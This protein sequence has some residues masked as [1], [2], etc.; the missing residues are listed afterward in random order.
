MAGAIAIMQALLQRSSEGGSYNIDV[1]LN[2][3]NNWL[4][5][6]VGIHDEQTQSSIRALHPDFTPRHDT[7][8]FEMVPQVIETIKKSNGVGTGQLWDEA[9]FTTGNIRWGKENEQARYLDWNQIVSVESEKGRREGMFG[10]QAESC[11]PGSDKP[12]W[13]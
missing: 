12:H 5:R 7:G 8:F 3:F 1:S 9:R 2:Q 10:F 11:M 4:L 13:L 6:D